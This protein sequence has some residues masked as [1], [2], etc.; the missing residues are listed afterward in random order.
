M[1]LAQAKMAM[2]STSLS[3]RV[4]PATADDTW[5]V[6]SQK[7]DAN[8]SVRTGTA[9]AVTAAKPPDAAG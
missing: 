7:P 4:D 9:V 1:T 6:K 3:P 5:V 8:A 2:A